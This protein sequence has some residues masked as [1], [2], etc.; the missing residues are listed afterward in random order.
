MISA[1]KGLQEVEQLDEG[2]EQPTI[3]EWLK[4]RMKKKAMVEVQ[5]MDD[6]DEFLAQISKPIE[7]KKAKKFS[8][9]IRDGSGSHILQVAVPK[10][11]KAKEDI[12]PKEYEVR[13]IDLGPAMQE[14]K[15]ED[16]D[17]SISVIKEKLR[18]E[19]E[20]NNQVREENRQLKEYLK[21]LMKP[22]QQGDETFVPPTSLPRELV[23]SFEEMRITTNE[24]K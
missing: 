17:D 16:L 4:E 6:V 2:I 21:H 20:T 18:K 15:I 8:K 5:P 12:L 11:D 3:P 24:A 14:Q 13:K 7:K 23:E 22:I 9:I 19:Q 10:V 1:L